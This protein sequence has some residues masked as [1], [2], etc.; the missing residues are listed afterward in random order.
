MPKEFLQ[1]RK[2]WVILKTEREKALSTKYG[3]IQ[4]DLDR[5]SHP[6]KPLPVGSVVQVQNQKGNDPLRWDRSD[7]VVE[8]L[9]NQ[10][11]SIKMDGSGRVTL[12][13]RRFLR[14]KNIAAKEVAKGGNEVEVQ[15]NVADEQE[16]VH[17]NEI[18]LEQRRSTRNYR[19]TDTYAP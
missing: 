17:G 1:Q 18:G 8:D 10:Q 12:R 6:L 14:K 19:L 16:V 2:E 4:A 5:H 11:F 9:G 3:K 13:N 15:G 7:I